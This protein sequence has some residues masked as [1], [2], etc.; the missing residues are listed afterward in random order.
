MAVPFA[1]ICT[2]V[3]DA[4]NFEWNCKRLERESQEEMNKLQNSFNNHGTEEEGGTG[5]KLKTRGALLKRM[6]LMTDRVWS[7]VGVRLPLGAELA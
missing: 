1:D 3:G 6:Q 5:G 4:I 7:K 2:S